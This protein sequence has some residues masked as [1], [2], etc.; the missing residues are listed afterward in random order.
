MED[1]D[2]Q[3]SVVSS[4][5]VVHI[6]DDSTEED[7]ADDG[8]AAAIE[9][10]SKL[11]GFFIKL[12]KKERPPLKKGP[13]RNKGT[14]NR[15]K[16]PRAQTKPKNNSSVVTPKWPTKEPEKEDNRGLC[17]TDWSTEENQ[18]KLAQAIFDWDNKRGVYEHKMSLTAFGKACG[19]PR[20]SVCW[21][22]TC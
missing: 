14:K 18:A 19:V 8:T 13:G 21:C 10:K 6:S 4:P 12:P 2:D 5:D 11:T 17:K 22:V 15:K 9:G 7:I 3:Q 16:G 1:G 20:V